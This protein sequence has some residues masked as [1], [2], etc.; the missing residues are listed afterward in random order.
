MEVGSRHIKS[1]KAG[2]APALALLGHGLT[3]LDTPQDT[4]DGF[5]LWECATPAGEMVPPHT[6]QNHEAFYVLEGKFEIEADGSVFS[7]ER[8]DFLAI[9]PGVLHTYRNPGPGLARMLTI[10][11]PGSQHQRFFEALGEPLEPGELPAP[12]AG[13]PDF[14]RIASVGRDSGID[15]LPPVDAA[16]D[17]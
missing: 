6:E 9:A 7:C 8:G 2:T 14:E 12:L 4:G 15:F 10:V 11:S 3:F 16:P 1:V 5:F 17:D 13:P